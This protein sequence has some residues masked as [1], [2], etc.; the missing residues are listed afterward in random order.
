MIFKLYNV[1]PDQNF[2]FR[3]RD[4]RGLFS[5]VHKVEKK[6][7]RNTQ[8]LIYMLSH[9]KLILATSVTMLMT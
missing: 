6:V 9:E 8:R 1:G 4:N 7:R 3:M 2:D 5:P